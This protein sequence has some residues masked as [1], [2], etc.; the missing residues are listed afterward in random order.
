L[1]TGVASNFDTAVFAYRDGEL[2]QL[3]DTKAMMAMRTE[4]FRDAVLLLNTQFIPGTHT[5][6]FNSEVLSTGEGIYFEV[7]SDLWS[8]NADTGQ[9]T[10]LLPYGE[11]G[12]FSIAPDGETVVLMDFDTVWQVDIDGQNP[13]RI[14]GAPSIALGLG[15]SVSYPPV[16]WDRDAEVPTFRTLLFPTYDPNSGN[17]AVPYE[18]AEFTLGDEITSRLIL[19]GDSSFFPAVELSPDGYRVAQWAWEDPADAR[20]MIVSIDA[21]DMERQII[22]EVEVESSGLSPFVRWDDETH[23]TYGFIDYNND[24]KVTGWRADLC[25]EIVELPA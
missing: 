7:P 20:T 17:L 16:V 25:G 2:I 3:L 5:V 10:N 9:L 13:R 1:I 6:L 8:L 14:T 4:E 12:H 24:R 21:P 19:S 11:G 18:V 15:E 23:L 22:A